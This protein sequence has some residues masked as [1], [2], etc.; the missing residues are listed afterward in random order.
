[1]R[2]CA[3]LCAEP[4]LEFGA[5]FVSCPVGW[6]SLPKD[7]FHIESC[8]AFDEQADEAVV[9]GE[10]GL[11][12]G[13]GMRMAAQRIVATWVFAGVE[14]HP[15]DFDVAELGSQSECAVTIV[16]GCERKQLP[17]IFGAA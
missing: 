15:D 7:I 14:Q 4:R 13:R 17:E 5:A 11:M 12:Q 3:L 8:S 2:F 6:S 9:S 1:M 10:G 16:G